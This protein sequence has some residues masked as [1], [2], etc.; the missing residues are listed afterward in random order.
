MDNEKNKIESSNSLKSITNEYHD[1]NEYNSANYSNR[2]FQE[3][4][5]FKE[6]N[7]KKSSLKA[8]KLSGIFTKILSSALVIT[9]A[10]VMGTSFIFGPK[11]KIN[12]VFIEDYENML[13]I[14]I[15][16]SEYYEED[17]LELVVKN[18]FTDR[19]YKSEAF[20]EGPEEEKQYM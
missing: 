1:Y 16:F 13:F 7:D 18:E 11:S 9:M 2:E 4:T 20:E 6:F 3:M 12:D 10:V 8:R 15:I 5:S 19:V 17:N 14:S